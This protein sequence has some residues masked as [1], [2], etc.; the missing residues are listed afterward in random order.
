MSDKIRWGILSTARINRALLDPIRQA[1]RSELAA[2]ASRDINKAQ[3][4]ATENGIPKAYGSYEEM[5]ADPEI[6]VIYNSLPNSLHCEWTVKA[7]EAGKHVLCE[8]PLVTTL[9]ELDQIEAAAKA[10][11]VTIFEAFMYLHHPQTLKVK[12]IVG[13]GQLGELRLINSWFNFYLPPE[14]SANIRLN[15]NL[16]GGSLWDVGVYPNSLVIVMAHAG[17]PV[18]VWASQAKGETGVEVSFAGQLKFSNGVVAQISSGFRTPFRQAA[19]IV[20]SEGILEIN[21]PWKPGA[22]G[23][24][25][26]VRWTKLDDSEELI[27]TPAISPYLTEVVAMEACLLDGAAPLIPLSLSRDF[28]RTLLALY[29]SAET[30]RPVTL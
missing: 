19:Y 11:N 14:N 3:T 6:D 2:V 28:L 27:V 8:K 16:A 7:A 24:K 9:T 17:P 13:S 22:E 20:G 29:E 1:S 25:A 5:L 26:T 18:E 30:G 12:E 21:E 15:P 4:Y 10:N 23:K